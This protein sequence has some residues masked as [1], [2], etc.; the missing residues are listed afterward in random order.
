MDNWFTRVRDLDKSYYFLRINY[1]IHTI[2][3]KFIYKISKTCLQISL[4]VQ[5]NVPRLEHILGGDL[6]RCFDSSSNLLLINFCNI[7]G[8][9]T[10]FHFVEHYLLS[11]NLY[12]FS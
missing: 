11:S 2:F 9:S 3:S 6:H 1:D 10:N 7:R 4:G 12:F 5:G 8:L